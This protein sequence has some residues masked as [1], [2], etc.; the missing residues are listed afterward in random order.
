MSHDLVY[1]RT[2]PQAVGEIMILGT[3]SATGPLLLNAGNVSRQP[4]PSP[5]GSRVAFYVSQA[6]LTTGGRIDDIFAVDRNGMNMKQL[7]SEPGYDGEPAWSPDGARIAYRHIDFTTGRSSIWV[8]NADGSGKRNLTADMEQTHS[9]GNPA[10]S[11]NGSRIAFDAMSSGTTPAITGIWS[12]AADGSDKRE[13]TRT[14]TGF[15]RSPTWAPSGVEIAFIR[16]YGD[17]TDITIVT[18]PYGVVTRVPL[19][20]R[21][22]GAA[23][24]PDG[25]HIAFWQQ[26][27]GGRTGIY[28]VRADGTNARL[29]TTNPD[30]GGGYDPQWIQR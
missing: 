4:T 28:T 8:M 6:D 16:A 10:W 13:H 30:W 18:T 11:P 29:H 24:S 7:T 15:D 9:V 3:G 5:D 12:M 2:T 20:G 14:S 17:D 25:Q 26:V 19:P 1:H 27:A 22:E 21:Q 23:W